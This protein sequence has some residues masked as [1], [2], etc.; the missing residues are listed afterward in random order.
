LGF[1]ANVNAEKN[2]AAEKREVN[3]IISLKKGIYSNKE[4]TFL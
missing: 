3:L 4:K 1:S 2:N